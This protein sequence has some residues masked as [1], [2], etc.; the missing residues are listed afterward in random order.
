MVYC[1]FKKYTLIFKRPGGTSRGV[2]HTKDT[3]FIIW[4]EEGKTAF[5]ECNR[6]IDLSYDDRNGYEEKLADVCKRLPFE[7]ELLLD[8]LTEWPSIRFGVEMV[9]LDKSNG[10]QQILFQEVI[11]KSGFDIPTNGLIWMGSKEFM[12]E[13]IKEKLKDHYTSIK[14]KVGAVDFDTEIELLQFIRRQF[15]ADEVEVRLDANG[16]FSFEEAREKLKILSAYDISYIEQ[17]IKAGQWQEMAALTAETPI[18]IALDEELIG[19]VDKDKQINL[20]NTIQPQMVILKMALLGGFVEADHW[21][22][23]VE[24]YGGTWVITSALES[25][26]GLNAIAQYTAQ[27]W[28]NYAQGLGTGQLYTNNISG[29]Y[30]VDHLGLHYHVD[31]DWDFSPLI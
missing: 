15:S 22:L 2:L 7:K 17:P 26:I 5:G 3:Y 13:Q 8:E 9:L 21:K 30:T 1:Y 4:Q 6:F 25:N 14:L 10:S 27:G 19:I 18:K 12:Y 31:K 29:P 16:A 23:L 24:A 28:S 11:G 20:I